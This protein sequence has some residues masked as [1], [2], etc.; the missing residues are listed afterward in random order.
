MTEKTVQFIQEKDSKLI[1][2]FELPKKNTFI[3]DEN[4]GLKQTC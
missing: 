1:R 2:G 4:L 3:P